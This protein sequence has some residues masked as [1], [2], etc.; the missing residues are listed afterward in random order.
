MCRQVV[1]LLSRTAYHGGESDVVTYIE[2]LDLEM[3]NLELYVVLATTL[4]WG[5]PRSSMDTTTLAGS[6]QYLVCLLLG[7]SV[8]MMVVWLVFHWASATV[9]CGKL[10]LSLSQLRFCANE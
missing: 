2:R 10:P 5:M 4:K 3:N 1:Q 7:C 8:L 9:R 6:L